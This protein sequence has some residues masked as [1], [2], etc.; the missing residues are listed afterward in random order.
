MLSAL[1][2]SSC[3]LSEADKELGL[4]PREALAGDMFPI[5]VFADG[6]LYG[7]YETGRGSKYD[8]DNLKYL[9]S[10]VSVPNNT[11]PSEE[12]NSN[13]FPQGAKVY[14]IDED[15]L[16]ILYSDSVADYY[17]YHINGIGT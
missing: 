15:S 11:I 14:R 9:G 4:D 10:L 3:G 2:L 17:I 12:L 13:G 16:Y 7:N 6:K 5:Y 1:L 8:T